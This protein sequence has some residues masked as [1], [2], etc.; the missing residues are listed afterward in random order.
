MYNLWESSRESSSPTIRNSIFWGH[1][2]SVLYGNGQVTISD[3]LVQGG[4]PWKATCD[5][6]MLDDDPHF[7]RLPDP[8]DG[9]W[10]TL[11]DNDYGDLRLQPDSP[12]IDAGH[13]GHLPDTIITDLDGK[14]RIVNTFIDMGAYEYPEAVRS[15]HWLPLI[16]Q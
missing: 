14:P 16:L 4:C 10:S 13:N 12:A 9:D 1:V 8:G 6:R 2:G 3:S 15:H 5:G 7:I 11:E